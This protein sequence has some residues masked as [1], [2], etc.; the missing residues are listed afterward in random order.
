MDSNEALKQLAVQF[1]P[2]NWFHS[3]GLDQYGRL[4][5]YVKYMNHT[6]LH[7]IPDFVDGKQVLVHFIASKTATRDQFVDHG[8]TS[9]PYVPIYD[10]TIDTSAVV[11]EI[12]DEDDVLAEEEQELLQYLQKELDLL[13]KLCGS[14]TLQDIFYECHDENIAP[15]S[16]VTNLSGRYPEVRE[17]VENLYDMYGFDAIYNELD[18]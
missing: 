4:V 2:K 5:V 11:A 9:K 14:N 12:A 15:G 13:E 16:S 10:A 6:T 7:S 8:I 3:T 1:G 17:R 18:G